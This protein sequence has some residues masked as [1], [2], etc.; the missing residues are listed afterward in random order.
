MDMFDT[1]E[2]PYRN[3]AF[4]SVWMDGWQAGISGKPNTNCPYVDHRNTRGGVTYARGF[5]NAW[6]LG[7]QEGR[8]KRDAGE[9]L[10]ADAYA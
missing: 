4:R 5:I 1:P 6:H 8:K 2:S 7:W 9:V 3:A 10:L